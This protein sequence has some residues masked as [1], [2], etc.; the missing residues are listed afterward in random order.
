MENQELWVE[1]KNKHVADIKLKLNDF[2]TSVWKLWS[3]KVLRFIIFISVWILSVKTIYQYMW[4]LVIYDMNTVFAVFWYWTLVWIALW[5]VWDTIM[6]ILNNTI[7]K[8]AWK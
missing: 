4:M 2:S 1:K 5:A 7:T 3:N 6:N 8:Y